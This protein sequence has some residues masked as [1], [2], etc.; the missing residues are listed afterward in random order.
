[1]WKYEVICE[2]IS[3]WGDHGDRAANWHTL[4]A[5]LFHLTENVSVI[6]S[7]RSLRRATVGR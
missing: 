5:R 1:M 6:Y 2:S 7:L 4:A 3:L